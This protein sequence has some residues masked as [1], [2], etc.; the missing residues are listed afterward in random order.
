MVPAYL[1]RIQYEEEKKAKEELA[2]QKE[3]EVDR[4]IEEA[5]EGNNTF[6]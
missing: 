2:K 3:E 6:F 5:K 1:R 4:V